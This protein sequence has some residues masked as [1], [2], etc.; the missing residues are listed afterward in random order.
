MTALAARPA[1]AGRAVRSTD[2]AFGLTPVEGYSGPLSTEAIAERFG[3]HPLDVLRFDG[4]TPPL[5]PPYARPAAVARAIAS[6]NEYDHSRAGALL[7]AIAD[8]CGVEPE[9]VVLGC[10]ADDLIA[11]LA[12]A[13]LRPGDRAA[14]HPDRTYPMY[15]IAVGWA[16]AT[17]SDDE[18]SLT[19]TCRPNNPTGEMTDL[20]AARP[21][22]V[23]EAYGEY[24]GESAVGLI[25]DGVVV[26]RTFSKRFG[27]AGARVGYALAGT[28]MAERLR[29]RQSPYAV[30]SLS[31]ALALEALANPPDV[32]PALRERDRLAA[33]LSDLGLAPLPSRTNFLFVP[34]DDS[35]RVAGELLRQGFVVREYPDGMRLS[36]RDEHD[37]DLLLSALAG[38]IAKG[39]AAAGAVESAAADVAAGAHARTVRH[40]RATAETIMHARV[41]TGGGRG[42][43]VRTGLGFADHLLE[44]LS[45]HSGL[46]VRLEGAGDLET[47]DHHTAEDAARTLGE[48]LDR[49]CGDRRGLRRYG[50]AAIPM[51]EAFARASIDLAGRPVSRV[52]LEG[53]NE[54]AAHMLECLAQSARLTLHVTATGEN[55]HHIAEA[56]FKATGR[57]IRAALE[58]DGTDVA[59]TKGTLL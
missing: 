22:V 43:F 58:A 6:S 50:E 24:A 48:A 52:L 9:N 7:W 38:V 17:V 59:S 45:F 15:R 37:D 57:A 30:S 42:A 26:V 5:P 1:T 16:Q 39:A 32:A 33:R 23:D 53:D 13:F 28:E 31:V 21:L 18:P 3:L 51:D 41:S 12:R 49:L 10:G 55:S 4:N 20:P 2:S 46:N 25:E 47:G 19:F 14:I 40:R 34:L 8:Y 44:Q 54:T 36:V 56:A 27:L 29:E 11:L 35:S